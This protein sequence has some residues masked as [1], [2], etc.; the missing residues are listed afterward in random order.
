MFFANFII[1]GFYEEKKKKIDNKTQIEFLHDLYDRKKYIGRKLWR[2][3]SEISFFHTYNRN[4]KN[5]ILEISINNKNPFKSFHKD[6]HFKKFQ[7][8]PSFPLPSH[9]YLTLC[10]KNN[11]PFSNK[12][13]N[14]LAYFTGKHWISLS[15]CW[16]VCLFVL[17]V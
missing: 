15:V 16:L 8:Y 9:H 1:F 5:R 17:F 14:I 13:F 7:Q 4:M 10:K 2:K 6:F 3:K 12:R 11:T